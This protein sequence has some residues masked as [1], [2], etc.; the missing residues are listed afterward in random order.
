MGLIRVL[1]S[2]ILFGA[3]LAPTISVAQD[4]VNFDQYVEGA[5][6]VY[7]KFKEPSKQESENFYAFISAKWEE[8][9][10]TC[11]QNCAVDGITAGKEYAVKMDIPLDSNIE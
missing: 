5:L 10:G 1:T 2:T 7:S 11:A 4:T 6:L 3:M 9:S 8:N